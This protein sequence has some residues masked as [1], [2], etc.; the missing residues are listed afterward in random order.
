MLAR[1]LV[2]I[3]LWTLAAHAILIFRSF[4]NQPMQLQ[5]DGKGDRSRSY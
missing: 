3:G 5:H 2:R 1:R 4:G